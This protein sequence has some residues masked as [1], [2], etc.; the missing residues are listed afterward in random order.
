[1]TTDLDR[2]I[3]SAVADIVTAAPAVTDDPTVVLVT[4][5][6]GSTSRRFLPAAAAVLIV[7][8]GVTG[9]VLA[10]RGSP[11]QTPPAATEQPNGPALTD[12]TPEA[13]APATT[14]DPNQPCGDGTGETSVPNVA[15]MQYDM[16]IDTLN[17]AGLGSEVV[18]SIPDAASA[19]YGYVVAKQ[20]TIPGA[21]VACGDVVVLTVGDRPKI[22]Y[23]IQSGDTWESIA[24]AQGVPIDDLL[25]AN[26]LT[27]TTLEATGETI[28]SPLDPGRTITILLPPTLE[29]APPTTV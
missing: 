2:A 17:A 6:S 15:G 3:K 11:S 25:D 24:S 1:M 8:A 20:G 22:N 16:A 5:T 13:T 7:A 14:A 21:T 18:P 19:T 9:I 10:S 23:T 26:G 4:P 28:T 27:A 29:T 12:A